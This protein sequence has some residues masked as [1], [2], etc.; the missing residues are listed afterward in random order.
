MQ[1]YLDLWT[2]LSGDMMVGCLLDAGWPEASL[3]ETIA[4]I[5]VAALLM[6]RHIF[7]ERFDILGLSE[8]VAALQ[9][10]L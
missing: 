8:R 7:R 5:G 10:G 6:F 2:G 1:G 4:Q 3:R 9:A